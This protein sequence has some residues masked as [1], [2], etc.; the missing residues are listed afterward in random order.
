MVEV[1]GGV[2]RLQVPSYQLCSI[3]RDQ[4]HPFSIRDP[5]PLGIRHRSSR[6]GEGKP[7]LELPGEER[8]YGVGETEADGDPKC[9]HLGKITCTDGLE[10][11]SLVP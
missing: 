11:K 7:F 6:R 2:D 9:E 10:Y 5:H 1:G 3:P 8:E 4:L